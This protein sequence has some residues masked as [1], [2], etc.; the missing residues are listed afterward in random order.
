MTN[1]H[2]RSFIDREKSTADEQ[3]AASKNDFSKEMF[4]PAAHLAT[5][6]NIRYRMLS[7]LCNVLALDEPDITL[8]LELVGKQRT[9][10]TLADN[11]H[12]MW[13]EAVRLEKLERK[14]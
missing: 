14:G 13:E 6:A 12:H 2:V 5:E 1:I 11:S 7:L 8:S 3:L 9:F 10:S 4:T